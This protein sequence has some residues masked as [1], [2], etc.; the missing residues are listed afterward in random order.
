MGVVS[1]SGVLGGCCLRIRGV[2]WVLSENQWS[3]V[4]VV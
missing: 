3:E 4:D 2:R 1:E